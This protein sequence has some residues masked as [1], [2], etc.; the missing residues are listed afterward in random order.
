MGSEMCIRDS[1]LPARTRCPP[2]A[3]RRAAPPPHPRKRGGAASFSRLFSVEETLHG[4]PGEPARVGAEQAG[5]EWKERARER[6]AAGF[7]QVARL[8]GGG[9]GS[10]P[11]LGCTL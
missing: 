9:R 10:F 7:V 3:R 4:A 8:L 5:S 6:G 11:G 2:L 1:S